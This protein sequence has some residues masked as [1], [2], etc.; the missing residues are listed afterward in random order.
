MKLND[1]KLY[2]RCI[3]IIVLSTSFSGILLIGQAPPNDLCE[4]AITIT[5]GS[6]FASSVAVNGDTRQAGD[7]VIQGGPVMNCSANFYRDDVWFKFT[8]PTTQPGTDLV[9]DIETGSQSN[10]FSSG[11]LALYTNSCANSNE[12]IIC[13]VGVTDDKE[14]DRIKIPFTCLIGGDEYLIRVWSAS[15]TAA[16]YLTGA[17][18]FRIRGW[19]ETLSSN[20][21]PIWCNEVGQFD[22]GMQ[23]WT[24]HGIACG[25]KANGD[26]VSADSA[27]WVWDSKGS[28]L[29]GT[30]SSGQTL[31]SPSVCNGAMVM[32]SDWL[33]SRGLAGQPNHT[34]QCPV[35]QEVE[36]I[37]PVIDLSGNTSTAVELKFHQNFRHYLSQY[38]VGWSGDNGVTWTEQ[39]I[40]V[41]EETNG[42]HTNNTVRVHLKGISNQSQVRVKFRYLGNFYYWI[43]DDVCIIERPG[44]DLKCNKTFSIAPNNQWVADQQYPFCLGTEIENIGAKTMTGTKVTA[45]II[46]LNNN[47]VL[48][49]LTQ[50]YGLFPPDSIWSEVNFSYNPDLPFGHYLLKYTVSGD[51]SDFDGSNNVCSSDFFITENTLSKVPDFAGSGIAPTDN[52]NFTIGNAYYLPQGSQRTAY[53]FHVGISNPEDFKPSLIGTT[54]NFTMQLWKS[55]GDMNQDLIIQASERELIGFNQYTFTENEPTGISIY[56]LEVLDI[57]T[58]EHGV[59]LEDNTQYFVTL[60]YTVPTGLTDYPL[61]VNATTN[62]NYTGLSIASQ[63]C[64]PYIPNGLLD[65]GNTG[66]IQLST[67]NTGAVAE[68]GL[69]LDLSTESKFYAHFSGKVYYDLECNGILDT[70]DIPV[71]NSVIKQLSSGPI[72]DYSNEYGYYSFF[73]LKPFDIT[74]APEK[75]DFVGTITPVNYHFVSNDTSTYYTNKDF[76]LCIDSTLCN[77]FVNLSLC[78]P[79]RPGFPSIYYLDV[80]NNSI[81]NQGIDVT[82]EFPN[83]TASQ[84]VSITQADGGTINA[85]QVT[86]SNVSFEPLEKKHFVIHTLTDATT[87]LGTVIMSSGFAYYID[88]EKGE[89]DISDNEDHLNFVV[90][91]SYDPN[92][93]LVEPEHFTSTQLANGLELEYTIRFQNTGNFPATFISVIDTI[94]PELDINSFRMIA[95]SHSYDISFPAPNVIRWFFNNVNLPDSLSDEPGSHGFIRFAIKSKKGLTPSEIIKNQASIFFDFNAPVVTPPAET[96]FLT[97]TNDPGFLAN[98]ILYPS[99]AK[100]QITVLL[101]AQLEGRVDYFICMNDS[102]S[103]LH[104]GVIP[105][106]GN[107]TKMHFDVSFLSAGT[108]LVYVSNQDRI[109][110]FKFIK[111]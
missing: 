13:I 27:T 19:V 64:P 22:G 61:F 35:N 28:A 96:K 48:T 40:N 5:I 94:Q 25:N 104:K 15:G 73:K 98:A 36:L 41:D 110:A 107:E 16:A 78:Q 89:P 37:S 8:C 79:P 29:G 86:W 23:G 1:Y 18:T 105:N 60:K 39:E 6:D 82:F 33:D 95:A 66:D 69:I 106:I 83:Q 76:L 99:V 108:Y 56:D 50:D 45:E 31:L 9:I 88:P 65:V 32:N 92:D 54:A 47:N 63:S 43:I 7:G 67:F 42:N 44:Y 91:G 111:E 90:V 30:F 34:G 62:Y 81:M 74:Y 17:G 46:D 21:V 80:T 10:D 24:N 72:L 97:G 75:P 71:K 2:L 58:L 49:T 103:I 100:E 55:L 11:G 51:T 4:D 102:K 101:N 85:D 14:V 38:F 93:K 12:P 68:I 87:P 20:F 52:S 77:I 3:L 57:N 53:Y 70:T 109:K 84:Y 59:Q 26:T